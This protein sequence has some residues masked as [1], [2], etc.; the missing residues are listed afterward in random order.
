MQE[1]KVVADAV[2]AAEDPEQLS[3]EAAP[4]TVPWQGIDEDAAV[5]NPQLVEA[6][7]NSSQ[8]GSVL[9]G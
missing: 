6:A 8:P 2:E 4:A 3:R 7:E 1:S 9:Y 5:P